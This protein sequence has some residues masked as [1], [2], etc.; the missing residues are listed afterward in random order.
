MV[1][2]LT[3]D[4]IHVAIAHKRIKSSNLF[5]TQVKWQYFFQTQSLCIMAAAG[6]VSRHQAV[7]FEASSSIVEIVVGNK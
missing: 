1:E 2:M 3:Y 5:G 7:I 6:G 4:G